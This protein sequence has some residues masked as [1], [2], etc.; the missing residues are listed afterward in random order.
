ME[1]S[2][3]YSKLLSLQPVSW[4]AVNTAVIVDNTCKGVDW[5]VPLLVVIPRVLVSAALRALAP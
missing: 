4:V 5:V 1:A 3:V 2:R